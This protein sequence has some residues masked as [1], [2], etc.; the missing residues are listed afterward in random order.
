MIK[1]N[2]PRFPYESEKGVQEVSGA[3]R[4]IMVVLLIFINGGLMR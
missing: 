2:P 4:I 3:Y 1:R